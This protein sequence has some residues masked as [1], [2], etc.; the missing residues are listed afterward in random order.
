M[1]QL[2]EDDNVLEDKNGTKCN[3]DI[4]QFIRFKDFKNPIRLRKKF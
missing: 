2:D 4:C 3:R 1:F